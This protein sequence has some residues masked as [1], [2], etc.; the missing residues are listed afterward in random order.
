MPISNTVSGSCK[1]GAARFTVTTDIRLVV[2]CHCNFCR[3]MNGAAFS[4]YAVVPRKFLLLDSEEYVAEYQ[5][6]EGFIKHFCKR[7]GTPLYNL[8]IR[9]PK[10]CMIYLGTL[11]NSSTLVPAANIYCESMLAWAEPIAAIKKHDKGMDEA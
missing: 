6:A 2:N 10:S 4:T 9:Y 3:G 1:C 8:N 7:C 5:V 11:E